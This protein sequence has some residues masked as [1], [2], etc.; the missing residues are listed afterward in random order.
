MIILMFSSIQFMHNHVFCFSFPFDI[1]N[2]QGRLHGNLFW[3]LEYHEGR[4]EPWT[5]WLASFIAKWGRIIRIARW[6]GCEK[7]KTSMVLWLWVL[8]VHTL[9]MFAVYLFQEIFIIG[10]RK[11]SKSHQSAAQN[12]AGLEYCVSVGSA[13]VWEIYSEHMAHKSSL[14]LW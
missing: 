13:I 9:L 8:A 11:K 12:I 14:G 1:I 10:F 7:S 5:L 2:W 6:F 3:R 4:P